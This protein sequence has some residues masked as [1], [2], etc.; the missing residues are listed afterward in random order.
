LSNAPITTMRWIPLELWCSWS[1]EAKAEWR[2]YAENL[3]IKWCLDIDGKLNA[4]EELQYDL[5][6]EAEALGYSSTG[7]MIAAQNT[8]QSSPGRG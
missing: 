1:P 7:E 4:K 2:A 8:R 3:N 5:D 6:R